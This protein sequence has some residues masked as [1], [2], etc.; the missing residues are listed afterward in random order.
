MRCVHVCVS[1]RIYIFVE[2][3]KILI[4]FFS[5]SLFN[6]H[7]MGSFFDPAKKISFFLLCVCVF[8]FYYY[9]KL[10]KCETAHGSHGLHVYAFQF[11]EMISTYTHFMLVVNIS[12]YFLLFSLH[13]ICETHAKPAKCIYFSVFLS[14]FH[15]YG[16]FFSPSHEF[17]H[18]FRCVCVRWEFACVRIIRFENKNFFSLKE[19]TIWR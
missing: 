16:F 3:I 14:H 4:L 2:S 15:F 5:S 7:W 13:W 9:F 12:F 1:L 8:V 18:A 17:L 19:K 6:V 11:W 10:K